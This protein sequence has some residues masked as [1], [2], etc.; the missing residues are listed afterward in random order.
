MRV[1]P[2]GDPS[3]GELAPEQLYGRLASL[4]TIG[5][6]P[7]LGG[8]AANTASVGRRE[9]DTGFAPITQWIRDARSN[10]VETPIDRAMPLTPVS[11]ERHIANQRYRECD[12][13]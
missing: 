1:L 6:A 12:D 5:H 9:L 2:V 10:R 11:L 7:R 8:G 13:P 3:A 4:P